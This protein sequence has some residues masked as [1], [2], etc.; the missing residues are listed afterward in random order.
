MPRATPDTSAIEIRIRRYCAQH[1]NAADTVDGVRRW[2]LADLA[3]APEDVQATLDRLVD[4]GEMA[5][6]T[7]PDGSIIYM[8]RPV[9]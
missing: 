4:A 3:C 7:L 6:R 5:R 9:A 2:W 1:R 8:H